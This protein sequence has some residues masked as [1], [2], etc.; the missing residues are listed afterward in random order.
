M[1]TNKQ[2]EEKKILRTMEMANDLVCKKDNENRAY[3]D[4]E[5][6]RANKWIELN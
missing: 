2:V 5:M 6:V 4:R 1:L 3:A